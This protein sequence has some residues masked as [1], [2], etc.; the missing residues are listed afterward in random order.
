VVTALLVVLAAPAG[1][2]PPPPPDAVV[3]PVVRGL[4]PADPARPARIVTPGRNVPNPFVLIDEGHYYLYASQAGWDDASIP[5][6]VSDEI[7]HWPGPPI[8]VL[9]VLPAWA[10][11]GRTWAPDVRRIGDRYVLYLTALMQGV[12]PDTQCIGVAT[13]DRPEGPFDPFPDPL[14]CQ[15]DRHGSIDPRTFLDRDGQLWLHWKS[16]DNAD[17]DGSGTA[18]IYAQRLDPTGTR[19]VGDPVRIL[20]VTESWEGRIVEAP[21]MQILEGQYWLFYSGNWFNQPDYALGIARC[22]GPAGPCSKPLSEP[23][24]ATN[25]QGAGPG[26]GSV[27]VDE[28]GAVWI[29]YAPIAQQFRTLTPRPVALARIGMNGF[30]PYLARPEG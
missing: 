16:D 8:D 1:S 23:W 11:H 2:Q 18:S 10:A 30:G 25:A 12:S 13:A 28:Q 19:L 20:E 15:R 24:L 22:E 17:V 6:R 14:V 3:E 7:G 21:D 5:L 29:A 4:A 27:F 9:P 26:E